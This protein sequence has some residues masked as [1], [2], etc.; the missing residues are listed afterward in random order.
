MER[1]FVTVGSTQF[2][3]LTQLMVSDEMLK[4]LQSLGCKELVVQHGKAIPPV[5]TGNAQGM[6]ITIYD[7][8]A[9]IRS[10]IEAADVVVGHAGAG[11]VLEALGAGKK[12]VVVINDQLMQNH[13][14]E[15]A[16]KMQDLGHLKACTCANLAE[17]LK[18]LPHMNFTPFEQ[19]NDEPSIANYIGDLIDQKRAERLR[20]PGSVG[21]KGKSNI[22]LVALAA[23]IAW[24]LAN[25]LFATS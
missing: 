5:V 11:T 18:A 8:K 12:M 22:T 7:Y 2:D 10:D 20:G 9:S 4:V 21:A 1:I 6:K 14:S 3:L 24:I 19:T 16:L 15:L 17:T 25:L 23:I 13:Q